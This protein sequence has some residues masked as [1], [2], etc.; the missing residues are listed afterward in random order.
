MFLGRRV[1]IVYS[2]MACSTRLPPQDVVRALQ[3]LSTEKTIELVFNLGVDI[4]T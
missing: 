4:N 3:E 1:V 2:V